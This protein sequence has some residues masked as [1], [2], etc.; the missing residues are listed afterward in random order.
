M[1]Q[2]NKRLNRIEINLT[3]IEMG[4]DLCV[5][6]TGGDTPHLGALTAGSQSFNPPQTIVFDSHKENHVTEMAA[7]LLRQEYAGNFVVCCGVH[8]DNIEPRE[9][10]DVMDLCQ[11][12]MVELCDKLKNH[13]KRLKMEIVVGVTGATGTIYAVKLLEALDAIKDINIHLIMSD[14]AVAN[15]EIETEYSL[16]YLESLATAVYDNSN[17]AAKTS[18]GSFITDGMVILPC[19]MKTLSAIANGYDDNLISRTA[20]VMIKEGRKLV[21]SPRETPL[22]SIHLENMLKL[23]KIGVRMIPPMVSFY[24]HPQNL[25]DIINHHVM[26][27]L[28]QFGIRYEKANR[29]NG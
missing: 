4:K 23:S 28:D 11:Q 19:S 17:L 25:E 14:W 27:I 16:G 29:W 7:K 22:S 18:S 1:I 20:G 24:N 10:T 3:A 9:I 26:K 5:I 13:H 6:I 2:I 15:L 8:L 12:L 21:L